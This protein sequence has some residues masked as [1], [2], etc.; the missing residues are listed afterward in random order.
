MST[1]ELKEII[2]RRTPEER[3]WMT[4]YLLDKI[5]AVPE[6]R[7]T[8][9]ELEQLARCRDDLLAGRQSVSQAQAEKHWD[10]LET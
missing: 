3:K 2:D 5:F 10:E 1:A 7:Q 4:S 6:L 9:E 8:A